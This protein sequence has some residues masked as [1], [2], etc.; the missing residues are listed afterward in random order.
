MRLAMGIGAICALVGCSVSEASKKVAR[1]EASVFSG[2]ELELLGG[3]K[4][5]S[6]TLDGKVVLIVNVA[7][8]C[9]FT[10]QY[11]GLQKLHEKYANEGLVVLAVPCNQFGGQEPGDPKTIRKFVTDKYGISFPMLSK[12]NVKGTNKSRLFERLSQTAVGKEGSVKWNF[13][14][15]LINRQGQLVDRYSS[16]TGPESDALIHAIKTELAQK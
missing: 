14:K 3:E 7:S 1:T 6:S 10:P 15:F 12:Q 16:L 13:E 4:L 5:N 8:Q 11:N 9:G 2:L